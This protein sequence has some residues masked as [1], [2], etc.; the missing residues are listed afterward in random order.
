MEK[1]NK[2]SAEITL[3][4]LQLYKQNIISQLKFKYRAFV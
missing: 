4:S 2:N 1:S 3:E